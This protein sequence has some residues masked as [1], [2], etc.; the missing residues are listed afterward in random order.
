MTSP[1][2]PL[3]DPKTGEP[4]R[5]RRIT[6]I[7][8]EYEIIKMA[9]EDPIVFIEYLTEK[10]LAPHQ[11][12]WVFAVLSHKRVNIIACRESGKTTIAVYLLA[13]MIGKNPL[14]THFIGS[15]SKKQAEDRL[16]MVKEIVDQNVR[17]QNVF[18]HIHLDYKKPNN[19]S[20]FNVWASSLNGIDEI[21]YATYRSQVALRGSLKDSTVFCAG[22]GSSALIGRRFSGLAL[23]DDIHSEANSATQTLRDKVNDWFLRT[24]LSCVKTEGRVCVIC[25]RWAPTDH[26]GTLKEQIRPDGSL[27]WLTIET[28][29]LDEDGNSYWPEI[30]PNHVLEERRDQHGPIMW[31]L[32]Y[33]CNPAG[34]SSGQFKIEYLRNPMPPD[35]EFKEVVVSTDLAVTLKSQSDYTVFV[36]MAINEK[37]NYDVYILDIFR[38]KLIFHDALDELEKFCDRVWERYGKL[39]RV[40]FENAVISI[41]SHDEFK[42]RRSDLPIRLVSL[43]MK[44]KGER[45]ASVALKAQ[46]GGLWINPDLFDTI[47]YKYWCSE[48][49]AFPKVDH[50]D[51]CDA[52]SLPVAG[53]FKISSPSSGIIHAQVPVV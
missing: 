38:K 39:D 52:T 11:I 43:K 42:A 51:A 37:R 2:T 3:I 27:I 25:T 34:L 46:R 35:V 26:S 33:M 13:W 14:A 22:I 48:L 49:I 32:M 19:K 18:P 23:I 29:A 21:T 6:V 30:F 50:D 24:F 40:L 45:L 44:D 15:V 36:A 10:K 17:Y 4:F 47:V 5:E 9:R 1:P 8:A 7:Q 16:E 20:E 41:P 28:R 53:Y 12:K 31:E